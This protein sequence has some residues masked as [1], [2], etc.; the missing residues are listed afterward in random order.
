MKIILKTTAIFFI[1]LLVIP[2]AVAQ[3]KPGP[4]VKAVEKSLPDENQQKG[5]TDPGD[6][7]KMK[8]D[9][10]A[11]LQ[12]AIPVTDKP[13]EFRNRTDAD[14]KLF[15]PAEYKQEPKPDTILDAGET[16]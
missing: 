4:E 14:F 8:E 10:K 16:K 9:N 7:K 5:V 1:S 11:G 3:N 15:K 12:P 6:P 13:V 2:A